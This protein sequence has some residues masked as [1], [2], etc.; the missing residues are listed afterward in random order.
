MGLF[1][2]L[3]IVISVVIGLAL[4]ELLTGVGNLLRV[5]KTVR[6]YWL[7]GFLVLGVFFALLQQWW[8]SWD[9][10]NVEAVSFGTVLLNLL[11]SLVLFLIAHLMFPDPAED[12]DLDEYY[13]DQAPILWALVLFGTVVGTFAEP[14][15]HGTA[16]FT[17]DNMTGVPMIAIC[18]ALA[19]WK[20]RMLHS[21]GAPVVLTLVI[22]DTWL[23]TP[24]I[25]SA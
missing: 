7:H 11:P 5:R 2:F 21:L 20:N 19:L 18:L 16:V 10:V 1:E 4:S 17:A 8:E 3:M 25:S 14:I 15:L 22:V 13:Y 12:A 23:V 9:L 24:V 6:F